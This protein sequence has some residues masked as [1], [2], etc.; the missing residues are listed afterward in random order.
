MSKIF[1]IVRPKSLTDSNY[2]DYEYLIRW[3]GRDGADYQKMFYDAE[4]DQAVS[5][6]I[7][8]E[9][10]PDNIEQLIDSESRNIKLY[11]NDLSKNDIIIIGSLFANKFVTRLKKDGTVERYAPDSNSFN[12]RLMNGRYEVEFNLRMTDLYVCK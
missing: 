4:F 2:E 9:L 7:I 6:T 11:C 8:N 5:G 12:Y 3:I 1:K 10:D